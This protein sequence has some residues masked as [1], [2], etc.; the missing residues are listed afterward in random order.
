MITIITKCDGCTLTITKQKNDIV[1]GTLEIPDEW[2][3][4][5]S[6]GIEYHFCEKCWE[7][8]QGKFD[9]S[10]RKILNQAIKRR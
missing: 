8:I 9:E 5:T 3:E 1:L 7:K 4:I 2:Q 10:K 6:E